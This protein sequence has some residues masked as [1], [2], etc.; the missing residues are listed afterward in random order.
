MASPSIK[1][2]HD[3]FR[4]RELNYSRVGTGIALV[5]VTLCPNGIFQ[6]S[7]RAPLVLPARRIWCDSLA[8]SRN[9]PRASHLWVS[10]S[11]EVIFPSSHAAPRSYHA[12]HPPL[13]GAAWN[14]GQE[15]L[16]AGTNCGVS[17]LPREDAAAAQ[18]RSTNPRH[19]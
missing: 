15:I 13:A 7:L 12:E 9:L 19:G 11:V 3:E 18:L 17:C 5:S 4:H 2:R 10:I 16:A 8:A 6:R 14:A 1:P